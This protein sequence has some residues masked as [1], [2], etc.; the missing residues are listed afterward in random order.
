MSATC[1]LP[2]EIGL[3]NKVNSG[4]T[5]T[6]TPNATTAYRSGKYLFRNAGGGEF[7]DVSLSA[8]VNMGRWA[9]ASLFAD[10]NNDGWDDLLV[11]NGYITGEK[12]DDL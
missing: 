5:A 1:F 8:A 6:Q 12:P 9:W 2:P 4:Q 11:N 3:H 7:Q 10:L